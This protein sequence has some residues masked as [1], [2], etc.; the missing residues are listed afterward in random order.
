MKLTGKKILSML[1]CM[2]MLLSVAA[3]G[4]SSAQAQAL[5]F[6]QI[7]ADVQEYITSFVDPSATVTSLYQSQNSI[8]ET[9]TEVSCQVT[10]SSDSGDGSGMVTLL[11]N[12]TGSEWTLSNCT[13]DLSS[14]SV[15]AP[16]ATPEEAAPSTATGT[17]AGYTLTEV[18][19]FENPSVGSLSS[20]RGLIVLDGNDTTT[21]Y[22]PNGAAGEYTGYQELDYAEF[23]LGFALVKEAT[24]S[25]L[26]N[27]RG[28]INGKGEVVLPCQAVWIDDIAGSRRFVEVY[29]STGQCSAY[30]DYLL[31]LK[32]G[33]L[34]G[35]G[36]ETYY[37]GY[38][39]IFDLQTYSF[40][41]DLE[42]T[43]TDG[44]CIHANEAMVCV[45]EDGTYTLYD[46]SGNII[47]Q[48]TAGIYL[49]ETLASFRMDGCTYVF[50][51]NGE[52]F[53]TADDIWPIWG[54]GDFFRVDKDDVCSLVDSNGNAV[55]PGMT[56]AT[57]NDC[58]NDVFSVKNADE[59]AYQLI[60]VNG[61]ILF[62]STDES[63]GYIGIINE[64]APGW[65]YCNPSFGTYTLIS[66]YTTIEGVDSA[67]PLTPNDS[68]GN[69]TVLNTGETLALGTSARRL[70]YGMMYA[71]DSNGKYT[72][73]DLFTGTALTE[74]K[75]SKVLYSAGYVYAL[76]GS[77]W[78]VFQ[79]ENIY[80]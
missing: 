44:D 63:T 14:A 27:C 38:R 39:K 60:D 4:S 45:K 12:F 32:V 61:N 77:T 21:V 18:S 31:C 54:D 59:T 51:V 24:G 2:A 42:I 66:T 33:G 25:A 50:D 55:L 75:Y 57:I 65:W 47:T 52:R 68:N 70:T 64:S 8:S 80:K 22:G 46:A 56:F 67:S 43:S 74:A 9:Q 53:T 23:E 16:E 48:T 3:C 79:V 10:Y 71:R 72:I 7:E 58:Y 5:G 13:A 76:D 73:Y 30:D 49:S 35:P 28:L 6:D 69:Y 36:E 17:L 34:F 19:T 11:Y 37:T 41:G 40:V 78:H 29:Y 62:E 1:L 15:A 26:D 20:S